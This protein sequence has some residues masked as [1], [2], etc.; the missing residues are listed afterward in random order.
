MADVCGCPL[1]TLFG[2][3]PAAELSSPTSETS[4]V[5]GHLGNEGFSRD[6][7]MGFLGWESQTNSVD[8]LVERLLAGLSE[9]D[10]ARLSEVP[11]RV[12]DRNRIEIAAWQD[13]EDEWVLVDCS[14]RKS[15]EYVVRLLMLECF[16]EAKD[17]FLFDPPSH[18]DVLD[19]L[20]LAGTHYLRSEWSPSIF[21]ISRLHFRKQIIPNL[22]TAMAGSLFFLLAHEFG[23]IVLHHSSDVGKAARHV[24]ALASGF[25]ALADQYAID[26][27]LKAI[28][29]IALCEND[30]LYLQFGVLQVLLAQILME[31]AVVQDLGSRPGSQDPVYA[32]G[33]MIGLARLSGLLS[34]N[35]DS[36][37]SGTYSLVGDAFRVVDSLATALKCRPLNAAANR[38]RWFSIV[39]D[40]GGVRDKST[41]EDA[42]RVKGLFDDGRYDET[43]DMLEK[44]DPRGEIPQHCHLR[45]S[46]FT[47][48]DDDEAALVW[49]EKASALDE[50]ASEPLADMAGCHFRLGHVEAARVSA[51]QALQRSTQD[52]V[53]WEWKARA[54][55]ALGDQRAVLDTLQ[56][57]I[58]RV[59]KPV[60]LL[61]M[62]AHVLADMQR[63]PEAV[64]AL[65][66]ALAVQPG[67]ATAWHNRGLYSLEQNNLGEG[68]EAL[69]EAVK[70]AAD[71]GLAWRDLGTACVLAS[72]TGLP[73]PGEAE[74]ALEEALRLLPGE[75]IA[76]L[77]LAKLY[78]AAGERARAMALVSRALVVHPSSS[79]LREIENQVLGRGSQPRL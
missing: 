24:E 51:E 1:S 59:P 31:A 42:Q 54:L 30:H 58:L 11:V 56:E 44:L 15:L 7:V 65:D 57:G 36:L 55:A 78:L 19:L 46:A 47:H 73:S 76:T 4:L 12:V 28:D 74:R 38:R 33:H 66:E 27:S 3:D 61:L 68:L 75:E 16:R 62:K 77:L 43:L 14:L 63:L 79:A 52:S 64:A 17:E 32:H 48:L 69:R 37:L 53:A 34:A 10:R 26:V 60:N 70:L 41:L 49:Y 40:N 50:G 20:R 35:R 18:N 6:Q 9:R 21:E 8:W 2:P 25:E 5:A 39:Y 13:A 45:G 22:S 67:N 29:G 71:Q 72:A 23:H